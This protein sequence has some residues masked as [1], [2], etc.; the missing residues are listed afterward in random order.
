MRR[1]VTRGLDKKKEKKEKKKVARVF[2]DVRKYAA[3]SMAMDFRSL[4]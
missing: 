4:L 1:R 3:L 2:A